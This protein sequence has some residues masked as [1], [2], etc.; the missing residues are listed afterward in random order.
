LS[1]RL[2]RRQI[3]ERGLALGVA[4]PLLT[5]L[6]HAAP[7]TSA[8]PAGQRRQLQAG[9]QAVDSGAITAIITSGTNDVDPHSTYTTYGSLICLNAY[10]ML[11]RYLD[12]T[13][14]QFEPALA[15][16]WEAN[17]DNTAFTFTL[18]ENAL[19]HDGTVCNADAVKQSMVRF[20]RL[21]LGPYIVLQRFVDDPENQIEVVDDT[22]IRFNMTQPQPLFLAAMA[23]SYGPYIV[24]PAAWEENATEEDPWA[25]EFL[26]FN[27]V[28]TGPYRLVENSVN[29]RVLFERFEEYHGGWEGNHFSE[30]T[31]RVVP[32]NATRRQLLEQGEADVLTNILTPEDIEALEASET[33]TV[34]KYPSTRVNWAILNV[35]RLMTVEAR[36]GLCYAFPYDAVLEGAYKGLMTRSGPIPSTVKGFDPDV[37]LYP[38]DLERAREL[39]TAGGFA[40]G[41]T[42][43]MEIFAEYEEDQITA[44]LFQASLA[45]IGF[46]LQI[47]ELDSATLNDIIFGD[48]PAEE[49][50]MILGG[51]AWWPDYN[52]PHN[53]LA[54]NFLESATRGGGSNAGEW[55]NERFEEIMTEAEHYESEEQL[56]ELM[57][58]AQNIL[59]EQDPPAIYYGETIYY[60]VIANNIRGFVPNPLYLE[61]YIFY[62]M[63]R[64]E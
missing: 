59:T 43:D 64:E 18:P 44:Q 33:L 38:T 17:D 51:W 15:Q 20:R 50:A 40:E 25:H 32:E 57:I 24:S 5:T 26:S 35:P 22:T 61:S 46:N 31:L 10:E 27:A 14:D 48:A 45:E 62:E 3:L 28:G 23:S 54:P 56:Q 41:D 55:V 39:L 6:M 60:T 29:E 42:F 21:E 7:A 34:M 2:T 36:Q 4:T 52:D 12:D 11:I 19:F 1:G 47:T 53:H 37:F 16:S 30:V 8:A 63:Y 58:E 49:K 9:M 13:T